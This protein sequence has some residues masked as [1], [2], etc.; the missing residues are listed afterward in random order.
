[1]A[2][3]KTLRWSS[4]VFGATDPEMVARIPAQIA[5]VVV[6]MTG[7]FRGLLQTEVGSSTRR[8]AA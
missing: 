5:L 8:D 1:M 2:L 4:L 3:A 6:L 7:D